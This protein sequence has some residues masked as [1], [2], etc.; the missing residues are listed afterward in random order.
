MSVTITRKSHTGFR[1]V[2]TSMILNDLERRNG[3]SLRF[4]SPN[5]LDFRA[6]YIAVVEDRP[7]MSVKYCLPLPI[8]HFWPKLFC[9]VQGGVSAIAEHLVLLLNGWICLLGVLD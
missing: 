4:F 2:A 8:F 7:I 3:L 6:D 1:L 9:T 5:S